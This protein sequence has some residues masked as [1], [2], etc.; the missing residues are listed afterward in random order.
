MHDVSRAAEFLA[1]WNISFEDLVRHVR[2]LEPQETLL[3]IGSIPKGLANALSDIDLVLIGDSGL[4]R[5]VVL[6]ENE[7]EYGTRM[8]RGHEV[9]V[10]SWRSTDLERLALTIAG[11]LSAVQTNAESNTCLVHPTRM[12]LC[13][14]DR[15]RNGVPLGNTERANFWRNRVQL[16]RLPE[17]LTLYWLDVFQALRED[18][19]GQMRYG[20]PLSAQC[21]VRLAMTTLAGA[22]LASVGE[23]DTYPKWRLRLLDRH[24]GIIGEEILAG[25]LR[26]MFSGPIQKNS[27]LVGDILEFQDRCIDSILSRYPQLNTWWK[28]RVE[29]AFVADASFE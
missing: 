17:Y 29:S 20:D 18:M 26:Y 12:Q 4:D 9:H 14:L 23:T 16:D 1:R 10:E 19:L 13:L 28:M 22:V 2:P 7:F 6:R 3:L 25:F 5:G 27:R 21:H 11:I 24:R 15:M 8:L